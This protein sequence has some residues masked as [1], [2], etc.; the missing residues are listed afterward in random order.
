MN[1]ELKQS[2]E[3]LDTEELLKKISESSFTQEAHSLAIQ[4]LNERG[5]ETLNLP[6]EPNEKAQ[7][8]ILNEKIPKY[9][10]YI[11]LGIAIVLTKAY[12][13]NK[14][15][16]STPLNNSTDSG[17]YMQSSKSV[18]EN[19]EIPKNE[20]GRQKLQKSNLDCEYNQFKSTPSS[21]FCK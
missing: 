7:L 10:F 15:K 20:E 3:K 4:I 1:K 5:V 6:R 21:P 8:S 11:L 2:L 14:E 18:L 19:M 12:L 16:N 13:Q 9:F 17:F